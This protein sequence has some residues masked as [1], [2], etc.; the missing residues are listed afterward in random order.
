[1][2]TKMMKKN[3]NYWADQLKIMKKEDFETVKR[4]ESM[5]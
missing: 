1:M 5:V 3:E 4:R 2:H